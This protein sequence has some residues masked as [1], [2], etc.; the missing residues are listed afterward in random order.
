[1][2]RVLSIRT[3]YPQGYLNMSHNQRMAVIIL[4]RGKIKEFNDFVSSTKMS[5]SERN[6]CLE[7]VKLKDIN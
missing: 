7:S 5:E 3:V 6:Y 1:M 2:S 4:S